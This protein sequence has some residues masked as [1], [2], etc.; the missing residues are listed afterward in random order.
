M[1]STLVEYKL[2]ERADDQANDTMK[3]YDVIVA[4]L[5]ASVLAKISDESHKTKVVKVLL[6]KQNNQFYA[7]G[8]KCSHYGAPLSGGVLY[9]DRV[10]CH[11]HG[12]CFNIK[13]GDIEE[14]PTV[15]CLP[16]Y[17]VVSNSQGHVLL[18]TTLGTLLEINSET[19]K[20]N[21]KQLDIGSKQRKKVVIVGSGAAGLIAAEKLRERPDLYEITMLTK[22][23]YPPYDRP[24]LS[25]A[26]QLNIDAITL[27]SEKFLKENHVN[28][29][30]GQ[31][32][33]KVDFNTK[34]VECAGGRQF[35][36]DRLIIATG[37][38]AVSLNKPGHNLKGVFTLKAYNDSQSIMTY[39]N[40]LVAKQQDKTKKLNIVSYGGSFISTELA[41]FF[42][43]K[44]NVLVVAR[45]KPFDRL[46]GADVSNKFVKFQES[47]GV[48]F[49]YDSKL[50][51]AEFAESATQSGSLGHVVLNN[52]TKL[53]ADL[54]F[55]AI[56]G[57]PSTGFLANTELKLTPDNYILVD[58]SMKTSVAD[59][60]AAGDC[61]HFP[62]SCLAGFEFTLGKGAKDHVN[63]AHYGV[64]NTQGRV[65]A[66]AILN[67]DSAAGSSPTSLYILPFF[68]TA[69]FGKSIRFAGFIEKYDEIVFHE[70]KTKQNEFKFAAFYVLEGNVVGVCTLDWDPVCAVF[71]EA[72]THKI[73]VKKQVIE[74]DPLEIK[75]IL[76]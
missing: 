68:W 1:E 46:F 22:E 74:S 9:K 36:Y 14:Y 29:V 18:S 72:M 6:V 20:L 37:V 21:L 42:A 70:D 15:K 53:E 51:I 2:L 67:E 25:K 44:A 60:Y 63:I 5:D 4:N 28:Y 35:D 76:A 47:K 45:N 55:I 31:Q 52:G 19:G 17:S 59:V 50:D 11:W 58:K 54:A 13:T 8:A 64:A 71:A 61:V 23:A 34:K 3:E 27:R 65:A 16:K 41:S 7:V 24:K 10:R 62:R 57:R 75:K 12:A 43:D 66:S 48:K 49:L 30:T 33:D 39:F 69:H 40:E 73:L 56:G 26:L 32:V 38:E